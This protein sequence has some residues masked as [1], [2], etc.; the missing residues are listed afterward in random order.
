MNVGKVCKR[1]VV[2]VREF[3]EVITAPCDG[4]RSADHYYEMA[5]AKRVIE[6][7]RVPLLLIAAEDDPFV[8]YVSFLAAR[9]NKIPAI[10]FVAT[11]HGGHC[12]FISNKSGLERFWAE[13]RV[14]EFCEEHRAAKNSA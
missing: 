4:Y 7:V 9:A 12:G 3:D 14:V 10:R 2:T 5:S 6:D 13:Q 11:Q 8:P 1:N